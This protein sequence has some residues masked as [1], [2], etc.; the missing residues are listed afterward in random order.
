MLAPLQIFYSFQQIF[1]IFQAYHSIKYMPS[2]LFSLRKAIEKP[3]LQRVR[4]LCGVDVCE[5]SPH[6]STPHKKRT[7][8]R[9]VLV[10]GDFL[11][12]LLF[13]DPR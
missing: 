2:E 7:R 1:L 10:K 11:M 9:P 6:T 3:R 13:I 8:R 12:A 5:R 4:F